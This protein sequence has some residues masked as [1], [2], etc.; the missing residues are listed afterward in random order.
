MVDRNRIRR[1]RARRPE[2]DRGVAWNRA[3]D[4]YEQVFGFQ[5]DPNWTIDTILNRIGN[6]RPGFEQAIRQFRQEFGR[7]PAASFT[8]P[9]LR[10]RTEER[11][12]LEDDVRA[13]I[14]WLP[15]ELL[16]TYVNEWTQSGDA[17]LALAKVRQSPQYD[18]HFPGIKR[19]DGTLRMSESEWFSTREAYRQLFQDF[20]LN[21]Q[22]FQKR[23]TELVEGEVSPSELAGR[24]GAAFDVIRNQIPQV[25]RVYA[26]W[27][28][29]QGISD[30]GIFAAF[31]DPD[32]GD[33]ILNR[34]I[35]MAQ[36]A[37]EG[38]ARGFQ[39][40]RQLTRRLFQA[41]VGQEQ[42]QQFFIAAEGQLQTL[43]QLAARHRDP[44]DTFDL[45]EFAE[46]TVFGDPEQT[47]RI[48]RLLRAEASLFTDQLGAV[49]QDDF[50]L[51]GLTPR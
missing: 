28:G 4:F 10:E 48:R 50:A 49:A 2:V 22:L 41:G 21:D 12:S 46:A 33:A 39:P 24:L 20:G 1:R 38:L 42:A 27:F 47:R 29:E 44:D 26:R 19:D 25:K 51:T 43:Q 9:E 36:V 6:Q 7:I 30:Q 11:R 18:K 37:A 34:R 35:G 5:P 15:E 3:A 40:G 16:D 13:L 8:G 32:V 23:F 14:P 45:V 17:E 31:I